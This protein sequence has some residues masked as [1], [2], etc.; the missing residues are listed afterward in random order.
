MQP[1]VAAQDM[2]PATAS[3][4]K[5]PS[6]MKYRVLAATAPSGMPRRKLVDALDPRVKAVSEEKLN[7][8]HMPFP[9]GQFHRNGDTA[10]HRP[11]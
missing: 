7:R 8:L 10:P 2:D 5:T 4:Q 1:S 11:R 3:A 9:T 6:L